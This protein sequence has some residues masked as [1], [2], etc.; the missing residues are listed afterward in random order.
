MVLDLITIGWRYTM[1]FRRPTT[2]APA[3]T[4][5]EAYRQ[6][7][8]LA[9]E[10]ALRNLGALYSMAVDDHDIDTVVAMFAEDGSFT[11]A[12]HTVQG[13]TALRDF[14]IGMM[15][16]YVTTLH[17]PN[18]H[19]ITVDDDTATG[20]LT[21]QAE[22]SLNGT[23]MMAAYRYDDR[24]ARQ[25]GRWVFAARTLK[26]MY[27]VPIEQMPTSFGDSK[28]IRWPETPYA[29]ADLPEALPTWD[30]YKC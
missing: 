4:P 17:I 21:G 1:D 28:R 3:Q 23:L 5:E 27:V 24:Y 9:D 20:I 16:R 6:L 7:R 10:S 11:R 18:S 26:F 30:S 15:D 12:G 8:S 13:H 14:Y 19:V 29:E 22:L 25:D 2:T